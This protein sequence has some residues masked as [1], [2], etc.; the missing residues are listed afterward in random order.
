MCT[1]TW[2]F[3]E[4]IFKYITH[5]RSC[6]CRLSKPFFPSPHLLSM[7]ERLLSRRARP[8]SA[9]WRQELAHKNSMSSAPKTCTA[10]ALHKTPFTVLYQTW[11][12]QSYYLSTGVYRYLEQHNNSLLLKL[13]FW[14][15]TRYQSCERVSALYMILD[16]KNASLLWVAAAAMI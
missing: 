12:T 16:L 10:V 8:S 4:H 14:C 2:A 3:G 9:S 1:D 11:L 13:T 5:I 7:C 15:Q 6:L